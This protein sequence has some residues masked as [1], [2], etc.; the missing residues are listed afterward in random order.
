PLAKQALPGAIPEAWTRS[1]PSG[2]D[3]GTV[4][5]CFPERKVNMRL[6][7]LKKL[8]DA[9]HAETGS[10]D[11]PIQL[12][13]NPGEEIFQI[14][15]DTRVQIGAA[16]WIYCLLMSDSELSPPGP[17]HEIYEAYQQY[18]KNRQQAVDTFEYG[19]GIKVEAKIHT[20]HEIVGK[21]K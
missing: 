13:S 12:L 6:G 11:T 17:E 7:D 3:L 8:V 10:W 5:F 18:V 9:I 14:A 1:S 15:P 21:N 4:G 2:T 16:H 19:R 20:I